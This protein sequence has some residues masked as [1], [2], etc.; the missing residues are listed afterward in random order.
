MIKVSI[1]V[2]FRNVEKYI[3]KCLSTIIHQTIEDIEI[4]CIDDASEDSSKEKVKK[5]A[6]K[7]TRIKIIETEKVSGQSYCR[8]LGLEIARGEYIGFVDSDDW[9]E[10][11]MYEKMY[12]SAKRVNSDITMCGASLFDDNKQVVYTDDYYSLKPLE[13]YKGKCF[14]AVDTKDEILDINVVLW[15]KIYKRE[16]LERTKARFAEG[17]IYEDLLFFFETY[18]KAERVNIVFENLYYYRQNRKSST[19]QNSDKK[20]YDRIPMVERTYNVLKSADFFEEKKIDIVCWIIDDI[21][22]RYTVLQDKY[23][24]E[25][26]K[27]MKG[28]FSRIEL[29]R[30]ELEKLKISYCYDEFV[31]ILERTYYGFWNYLIEKYKTSNKRI[32]AAEHKCNMDIKAIKEYIE[33]YKEETQDEKKKIEKWWENHC[34]EEKE[35]LK[36]YLKTEYEKEK[37]EIEEA[38]RKQLEYQEQKKK[39]DMKAMYEK[40]EKEFQKWNKESLL[41]QE[42]NIK[43]DY[44]AKLYEQSE[45]HKKRIQEIKD[46]Y[47]NEFLLVKMIL[48]MYKVKEQAL[49]KVK[50]ILKKN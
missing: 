6:E 27:A 13:G 48:K 20:V 45:N 41:E 16:F 15:N 24:E 21:F 17:Y 38:H 34:E 8:N 28:F 9:I 40:Q 32:K 11:D 49:N 18:I 43:S 36:E 42:R 12:H 33:E 2:P 5:Y 39:E 14:K 1:I 46:Y 50:K 26:Y 23:Y 30:E 35:K 4:I 37:E 7:D 25:Y 3:S 10:L 31:N 44:Q 47:E 29:S 22:H 19:M